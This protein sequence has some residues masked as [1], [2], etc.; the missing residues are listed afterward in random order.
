M[1]K[2]VFFN[3][4]TYGHL[5]PSLPIVRD[6]VQAG[7]KVDYYSYPAALESI[8]L[9]EGNFKALPD[10]C[11][12]LETALKSTPPPSFPE[13]NCILLETTISVMQTL[14][15]DL[16]SNLPDVIISDTFCPWGYILAKHLGIRSVVLHATFAFHPSFIPPFATILLAIFDKNSKAINIFRSVRH[17]KKLSN[18]VNSIYGTKIQSIWDLTFAK[19]NLHLIFISKQ[20][21]YR[22]ERFDSDH[23]FIGSTLPSLESHSDKADVKIPVIYISLGTVFNNQIDFFKNC[24]LAFN[25]KHY[26]V[27]MSIGRHIKVAE[28]EPIPDNFIV[29][30]SVNQ[31]AVLSQASVF[32]THG[33]MNSVSEAII[34]QVPMLLFP[35]TPEQSLISSR[36]KH[37]NGG[38][39]LKRASVVEMLFAVDRLLKD[40]SIKQSLKN[41]A[42]YNSQ[43]GGLK[44]ATQVILANSSSSNN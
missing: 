27:I 4:P 36:V 24:I 16:T 12:K 21:Q 17:F 44:F 34:N 3:I 6:L 5:N 8:E 1:K 18:Q 2:I 10:R 30:T 11:N 29:K 25:S 20:F 41:L 26:K 9:Y 39:I 31:L 13:M 15:K 40:K 42:M 23:Y 28:L 32:I 22:A 43:S 7:H 37:F 14:I 38:L 33:G 19:G 35:Q